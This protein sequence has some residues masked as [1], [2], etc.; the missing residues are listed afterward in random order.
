MTDENLPAARVMLADALHD[1]C[2]TQRATTPTGAII[3]APCLYVQLQTATRDPDSVCRTGGAGG[4]HGEPV[5][6]DGLVLLEEIDRTTIEW[7]GERGHTMSLLRNLELKKWRPQDAGVIADI[8]STIRQWAARARQL[9]DGEATKEILAP[10]PWC[11]R[12]FVYRHAN[13]EN[14]KSRALTMTT[15]GAKCSACHHRWPK[16]Q[17]GLLLAQI[18]ADRAVG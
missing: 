1:L 18:E 8:A 14:V 13:G 17:L 12:E 5:W 4:R 16:H 15:E 6:I 3:T 11:K 9:L 10:C 2:S 7:A